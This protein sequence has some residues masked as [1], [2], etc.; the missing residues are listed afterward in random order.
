MRNFEERMVEIQKRSHARIAHRRKQITALCVPL[1]AALC[2]GGAMLL[3]QQGAYTNENTVPAVTTITAYS[4]SVTVVNGKVSV[5]YSNQD[6]VEGMRNLVSSLLPVQDT[7]IA[8]DEKNGHEFTTQ[9]TS[10]NVK[11]TILLETEEGSVQYKL[12]G[13]ILTNMETGERYALTD[14]QRAELLKVLQII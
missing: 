12:L 4:G 3:P 2:V 5:T 7:A 1:V 10:I 8:M 6:T 11:Y 13:R 9:A 14:A